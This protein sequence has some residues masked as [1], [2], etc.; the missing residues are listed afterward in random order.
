MRIT[1]Y[2]EAAEYLGTKGDRP[3]PGR[4][5]RI[6]RRDDG[7]I[8]I[9]YQSTDVITYAPTGKRITLQNGGWYTPT[10]KARITEYSRARLYSSKGRWYFGGWPAPDDGQAPI[11]F[12][13]G[14]QI[15]ETG[16]PIKGRR[17]G[18]ADRTLAAKLDRTVRKYIKAFRAA[19]EGGDLEMPGPGDC[20]GCGFTAEAPAI[21]QG[22]RGRTNRPT[23][24]G[25]NEVM[26]I[27]HYLSHLGLGDDA[28]A[29]AEWYLV[30]SLLWNAI[31]ARGYGKPEYI[32]DL[33]WRR[34]DGDMAA[35]ILRAYFKNL[36][37]ALL[38]E[39]QGRA[40]AR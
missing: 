1:T 27:G 13:D 12:A 35:G 25:R 40:G 6:Q 21:G 7:S 3:L 22:A 18:P 2:T 26:G 23:V 14:M 39:L 10:T 36:K 33:I 15:R 11:V 32:A 4:A 29:A 17:E 28:D 8:A 20:W 24:H 34:H 16:I 37:P 38:A 5:T 31:K 9:K 30:P 19:V